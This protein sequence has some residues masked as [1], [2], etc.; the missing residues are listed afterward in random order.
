MQPISLLKPFVKIFAM[1]LLVC[2]LEA[3]ASTEEAS[4]ETLPSVE[5]ILDEAIELVRP[6]AKVD[7]E[8]SLLAVAVRQAKVRS[9]EKAKDLFKTAAD[10]NERWAKEQTG[11]LWI[12]NH[13]GFLNRLLEAQQRAG[14]GEEMTSTAARLR[15][16]YHEEHRGHLAE[17]AGDELTTARHNLQL[18]LNLG[19]LYVWMK[20][21][22]AARGVVPMIIQQIRAAKWR[23]SSV[24]FG[25]AAAFLARMGRDD[26][27]LEV[28]TRYDQFYEARQEI[29]EDVDDRFYWI[30]RVGNLAEVAAAQAEAGHTESAKATFRRAIEKARNTPVARLTKLYGMKTPAVQNRTESDVIGEGEALQS[31]GLMRI[32]WLATSMGETA[33]ALEALD[34]ASPFANEASGTEDLIR[35]FARM[36]EVET[37]RKLLDRFRCSRRAIV[38][39]LLEKQDWAGALEADKAYPTVSCCERTCDVFES[40]DISGL[41][42]ARTFVD[43]EVQALAWARKQSKRYKVSALLEVVDA[44]LEQNQAAAPSI[45]QSN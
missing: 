28:V 15:A 9:C 25:G 10:S 3:L 40:S 29:T 31:A 1:C 26:E 20:N 5:S 12:E 7:N 24:E 42:K 23:P 16:L 34:L 13:I 14:C 39:V 11:K 4:A 37:A 30:S 19:N 35:A 32:V 21:L 6:S 41:A 43:G 36:G 8:D 2:G 27:A 45:M 38:R 44:L 17:S 22:D 33:L 18:L